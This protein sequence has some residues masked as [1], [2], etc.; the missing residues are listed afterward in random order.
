[1]IAWINFMVLLVAGVAMFVLYALSVSPAHLERKIGPI[2][3][4]RCGLYR[5]IA[6]AIM[7]VITANY[8]LYVFY[9]LP[10]SLPARFPWPWW[11]SVVIAA[12]IGIP[13][14]YI[15]WRG[16]KDAGA[17]AMQP[18]KEHTMYGGIYEKMR[19]PQA[20]GEVFLWWVIAFLAHSPFLALFS[21]V[22]LPV[23]AGMC[24]FEDRDLSLR[25]GAAFD[26]YRR[27]VGAFFPRRQKSA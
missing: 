19:H 1:M 18:A 21:F 27:R 26:A 13:S 8:V 3:Y 14:M 24:W 12:A 2:A 7:L 4:K 22:W 9:P 16:I 25:Y 6:G 11:V 20:L 23:W 5:S 10:L 15:M 17:E